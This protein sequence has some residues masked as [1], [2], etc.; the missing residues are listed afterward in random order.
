[1][2]FHE[3]EYK[4]QAEDISRADF[5]KLAKSLKPIKEW[6]ATGENSI[7]Y[8]FTKKD[9]FMRFRTSD[10]KWELT[11]KYK[12]ADTNNKVRI[13]VNIK[14]GSGM[15][16]DKAKTFAGVFGLEPDFTIAKDVQVYWFDK[17][18]LSHY[19]C[20]GEGGKKL[21]TFLEIE[22]DES[23][24]WESEEQA[25]A[26]LAEWENKLSSLGINAYKRIRRSLFEMYTTKG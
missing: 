21:D 25:L 10:S 8:Y 6:S 2:K 23:Y 1:M 4:Y 20:L 13:E 16:Y 15:S 11:T 12:T 3:I 7:D 14:L 17:I 9:K 24:K 26:E 22:C 19:T 5:D 18:V